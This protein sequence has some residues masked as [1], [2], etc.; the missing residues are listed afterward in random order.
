M[1]GMSSMTFS[2]CLL[3]GSFRFRSSNKLFIHDPQCVMGILCKIGVLD[4]VI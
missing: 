3:S 1:L 4:K 2:K